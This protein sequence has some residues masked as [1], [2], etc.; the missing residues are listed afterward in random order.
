[1]EDLTLYRTPERFFTFMPLSPH[2]IAVS[3]NRFR[4]VLAGPSRPIPPAR[5]RTDCLSAGA[6][7]AEAMFEAI[8]FP[9]DARHC[10]TLPTRLAVIGLSSSS[11]V[12]RRLRLTLTFLLTRPSDQHS[13]C[14]T[15]W[16]LCNPAR[17]SRCRAVLQARR[18]ICGNRSQ[19]THG[20]NPVCRCVVAGRFGWSSTHD[21]SP[22]IL[23]QHPPGTRLTCARLQF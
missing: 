9:Q 20:G 18:V 15:Y 19:T 2:C 10:L 4:V 6:D 22:E 5:F 8:V 21:L 12:A 11:V 16:H 3:A 23:V 17:S 13:A 1:M 14:G 7:V